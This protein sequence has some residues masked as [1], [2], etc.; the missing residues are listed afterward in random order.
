[1]ARPGRKHDIQLRSI[2]CT[3]E[4]FAGYDVVVLSTGHR[5]FRDPSLYMHVGLVIDTRNI[6][7]L[8]EGASTKL[9]RA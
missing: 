3:A 4:A 2:A 8:P 1:V 7:K 6:V 9:V 5:Q